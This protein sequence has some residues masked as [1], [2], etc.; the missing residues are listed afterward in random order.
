MHAP[1]AHMALGSAC[2]GEERGGWLVGQQTTRAR[3][4]NG[5]WEG[6]RLSGANGRRLTASFVTAVCNRERIFHFTYYIM[7]AVAGALRRA[8]AGATALDTQC[9]TQ[10]LGRGRDAILDTVS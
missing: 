3:L 5:P 8:H 1:H 7:R 9:R 2:S 6:K 10:T 4:R